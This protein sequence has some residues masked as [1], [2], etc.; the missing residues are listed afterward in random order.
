[1][2]N[3]VTIAIASTFIIAAC[4]LAPNSYTVEGI[5]PDFSH[6]SKMVYMYDIHD[7]K[8]I[9]SAMIVDGKFK[10]AGKVTESTLKRLDLNRITVDFIL[11][12]GKIFVEMAYPENV[13]GTRLNNE[14]S[15]LRT[16]IA[17]IEE[18]LWEKISE[19]THLDNVKRKKQYDEI[20]EQY[21]E[22]A[23]SLCTKYFNKNKNN[24]L[25]AY[26]LINTPVSGMHD[27]I[28]S[29]YEQS[30][31]FVR[32]YAPVQNY[33]N[34]SSARRKSTDVGMPFT[35][36]TI[37]N[38]NI[39]GSE[40]SLSDYV[41]KGNYVLVD[42]W[43]TVCQPCIAELPL[44]FELYDKYKNNNF[45]IL[46][47]AVWEKRDVTIAGIE[48]HKIPWQH[49]IDTEHIPT[50]LYGIEGIPHIILFG[51]DGKILARNL[52]GNRLKATLAEF[53]KY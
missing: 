50:R 49:I 46:G 10:F 19:I 23:I 22:K 20:L 45:D 21:R 15:K 9:D 30:G 31:D 27:V 11:E 29:L 44:L 43:N 53:I 25:G 47:V 13:K 39:D 16:E 40:A 26:T 51:P 17:V 1:M 38:G 48:K 52:R 5:V 4:G 28:V 24:A 14:L 32:N 33:V 37:E 12:K 18:E 34:T 8:P 7:N 41:G 36:F 42:F 35:N 2:K 3:S 6:N